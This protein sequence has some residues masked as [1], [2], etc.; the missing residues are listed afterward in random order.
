M[1]TSG[2]PTLIASLGKLGIEETEL[3]IVAIDPTNGNVSKLYTLPSLY[4][5]FD[6]VWVCLQVDSERERIY[7][8]VTPARVDKGNYLYELSLADGHILKNY[9]LE[10]F[11]GMEE[12][13]TQW[14]FNPDI[15]TLYGLCLNYTTTS[16]TWNYVWCSV[17]F[18]ENGVGKTQHG[19]YAGTDEDPPGPGPCRRVSMNRNTFSTGEYWYTETNDIFVR[20]V[21]TQTGEPDELIWTVEDK[22]LI[23]YDP[24]T[25]DA[26]VTG[27]TNEY[28]IVMRPGEMDIH[29]FHSIVVKLKSGGDEELIAKLPT[30]LVESPGPRWAYDPNTDMLYVLMRTDFKL[31]Y[32]TL[33]MVN[34]S[35]PNSVRTIPAPIKSLYDPGMYFVNDM[36]LIEWPPTT[37][38][39]P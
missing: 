24:P 14:D 6:D 4:G 30:D 21:N 33:V 32:D 39:N 17:K 22:A 38:A 31:I 36:H 29:S 1:L 9:T 23:A 3:D 2:K 7:V 10:P 8:L 27:K 18:D 35:Q 37:H 12:I 26:L 25:F 20:S 28:A 5:L 34:L 13:Y 19:F 15:R 11:L 16:L